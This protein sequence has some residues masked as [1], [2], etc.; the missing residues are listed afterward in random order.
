MTVHASHVAFLDLLQD[1]DP[2]SSA[3]K[4]ANIANLVSWHSMVEL[5]HD[6]VRLA[7]VDA[8]VR[9]KRVHDGAVRGPVANA[10]YRRLCLVVA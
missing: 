3:G 10:S 9:E 6:D 2:N 1:R 8:W 4:P 7:A 5:E